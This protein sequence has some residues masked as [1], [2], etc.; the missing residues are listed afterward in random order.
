MERAKFEKL[1]VSAGLLFKI[2][3]MNTVQY[4]IGTVKLIH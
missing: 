4:K 3:A 1:L 2:K